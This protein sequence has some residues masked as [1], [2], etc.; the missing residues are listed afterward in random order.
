MKLCNIFFIFM[1]CNFFW[2]IIV[3]VYFFRYIFVF[4]IVFK[5]FL[6][7][8]KVLVLWFRFFF[9]R[10]VIECLFVFLIEVIFNV[11]WFFKFVNIFFV[12]WVWSK[13]L[14]VWVWKNC[15]IGMWLGFVIIKE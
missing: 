5:N 10:F 1:L 13:D 2:L 4:F 9:K 12:C 8:F 3:W 14:L 11:G 15:I 6:Y 7:S